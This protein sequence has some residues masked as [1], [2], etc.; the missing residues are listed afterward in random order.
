MTLQKEIQ[1]R[2]PFDES[3]AVR[4]VVVVDWARSDGTRYVSRIGSDGLT[5]WERDGLLFHA[6][7]GDWSSSEEI[8]VD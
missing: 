5:E 4:F 7:H 6:L 3:I 2:A 1:S 8:D